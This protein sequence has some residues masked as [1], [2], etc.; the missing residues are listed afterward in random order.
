MS[1]PMTPRPA[2]PPPESTPPETPPSRK[3]ISPLLWI[4]LLVAVIALAWYFLGG[5]GDDVTPVEVTP[6]TQTGDATVDE[7][8]DEDAADAPADTGTT[9]PA[10][11][12]A[13][14][15]ETAAAPLSQ[16]RPEYPREA[17]RAREE[18]VVLVQATI[19]TAGNPSDIS[20][21]D[22]SG[23]RALDRAAHDAV[24]KW[25][26]TPATRNG[27]KIVSTVEVPVEFKLADQ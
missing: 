9:T 15:R 10:T 4:L 14:P 16:P 18:G 26:F 21:V 8:V 1:D 23:S 2:D 27:R 24:G 22:R 5:R 20:I 12:P 6:T 11:P 13:P 17:L 25:T 19:D 7:A 3:G